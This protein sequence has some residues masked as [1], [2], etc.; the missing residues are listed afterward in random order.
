M[1]TFNTTIQEAEIWETRPNWVSKTTGNKS[2]GF[3]D[4]AW[5]KEQIGD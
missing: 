1:M 3:S 2:S 4:R 5:L